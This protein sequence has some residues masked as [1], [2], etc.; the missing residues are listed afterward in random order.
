VQGLWWAVT[1]TLGVPAG[2]LALGNWL[3][4]VGAAVEAA[5]QGRS[6]TF[7]F[8][9][10]FVAGLA[11]AV[12]CLACPL[13]GLW[14]WAWLPL[15]LDPSIALLVLACV[16]HGVARAGGLRSPFDGAPPA[17]EQRRI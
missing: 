10:P 5:R 2:L 12:A 4:V 8:G 14:H 15:L 11:G 7:S 17:E 13:P 6:K 3:I 1:L 9:L 16:M